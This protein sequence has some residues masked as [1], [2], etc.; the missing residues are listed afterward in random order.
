MDDADFTENPR[1]GARLPAVVIVRYWAAARAA[2]GCAEDHVSA[3]SVGEAL[4]AVAELHT[5][6]PQFARVLGFSSLLLDE[7]R[8]A[9]QA[10]QTPVG[11]G[12]VIDV[13]PP[14]AGG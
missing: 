3:A 11:P 5:D 2:A 13:L 7:R 8:L 1:D 9:R 6:S 4:E 10:T 14:F 12:D